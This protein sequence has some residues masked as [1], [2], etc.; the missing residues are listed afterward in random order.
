MRRKASPDCGPA[1]VHWHRCLLDNVPLRPGPPQLWRYRAILLLHYWLGTRPDPL[2]PAG[3]VF[4]VSCGIK[5]VPDRWAILVSAQSELPVHRAL[6]K[7][8]AVIVFCP[9]ITSHHQEG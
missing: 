3:T 4:A 2:Q 5:S 1:S 9:T 6:H 7:E 8:N